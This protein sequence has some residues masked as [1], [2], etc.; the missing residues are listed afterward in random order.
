MYDDHDGGSDRGV[1]LHSHSAEG[2]GRRPSS[3]RRRATT[4]AMPTVPTTPNAARWSLRDL[5]RR[6]PGT[7]GASLAVLPG[8]LPDAPLATP[9]GV[10]STP[11]ETLEG[12]GGNGTNELDTPCEPSRR[13]VR[14]GRQDGDY[15]RSTG[16][17]EPLGSSPNA[18]RHKRRPSIPTTICFDD[19]TLDECR[20]SGHRGERGEGESCDGSRE[21]YAGGSVALSD[22]TP[23]TFGDEIAE[24]RFHIL[25]FQWEKD[26]I[27]SDSQLSTADICSI[28][29]SDALNLE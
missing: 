13:R 2:T 10:E 17:D 24:V 15:R 20:G 23:F 5:F 25:N 3:S 6:S 7:N 21:Y 12:E 18:G 4:D 14:R 19:S 27:S 29:N 22:V 11:D 16:H 26:S 28:R 8:C 9:E 1:L